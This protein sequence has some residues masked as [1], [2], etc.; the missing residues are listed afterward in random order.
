MRLASLAALLSLAACQ[1]EAAPAPGPRETGIQTSS[2]LER[3]AIETGAIADA[4]KVPAI[5]L[6]QRNHEAGRDALCVIPARD[7]DYRFGMEASFGE[8][9]S[10]AG[11][12]SARRAGDKL[13]LSFSRSDHCIVVAQYDGDQLS[14]P[15]VVDMKCAEL[16]KGRGSLEGVSFPRVA[17][18]AAAALQARDGSGDPL[19]DPD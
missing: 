18:D 7:G 12:G 16:C 19:C 10:C 15:G 13:I 8:G 14:L 2:G 17:S 6:Y 4:A 3:A 11:K 5:G 9:Q 1:R